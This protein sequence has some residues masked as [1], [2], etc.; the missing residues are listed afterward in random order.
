R[1]AVTREFGTN[2]WFQCVYLSTP[3][4][5][6]A[7]IEDIEEAKLPEFFKMFTAIEGVPFLIKLKMFDLQILQFANFRQSKL[8]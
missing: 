6:G 5:T 3:P 2:L 1:A 4:P 8:A 7:T